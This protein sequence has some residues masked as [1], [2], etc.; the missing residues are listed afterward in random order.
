MKLKRKMWIGIAAAGFVVAAAGGIAVI[1]SLNKNSV[2]KPP[3]PPVYYFAKEDNISSLTEVVGERVFEEINPV[4]AGDGGES[5]GAAEETAVRSDTMDRGG[6]ETQEETGAQEETAGQEETGTQEETAGEEREQYRYY[7]AEDAAADLQAYKEYLM[8]EKHFIEPA[9]EEEDDKGETKEEEKEED[10]GELR[11]I[12][13]G[14][15]SDEN[16]YLEI[17]L[18]AGQTACTVTAVKKGEA[19]NS[20]VARLYEEEKK[21]VQKQPEEPISTRQIAE[22]TVRGMSQ[23]QLA[24]SEPVKNY[25][26]I[27]NPGLI[28]VEGTNYYRISAYKKQE[29]GTLS[30]ECAYLMDFDSGDVGYKYDDVTEALEPLG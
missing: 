21:K 15:S 10:S 12:L 16:S 9:I 1:W 18:T 19:W 28:M 6:A 3:S 4:D 26:F 13:A 23:G 30:Y 17:T 29:N 22:D 2:P 20:Y 5:T 11:C 8:Q 7:P 24:L 25:E 14:P 27:T